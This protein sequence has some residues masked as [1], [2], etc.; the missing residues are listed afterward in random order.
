MKTIVRKKMAPY[1]P[2]NT[3]YTQIDVSLYK[4]SYMYELMGESSYE[5]TRILGV[6]YLWYNE[7]RCVVEIWGPFHAL[8]NGAAKTLENIIRPNIIF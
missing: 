6:D 2:P 5:L 7:Q 8:K 3:H 1:N 4:P